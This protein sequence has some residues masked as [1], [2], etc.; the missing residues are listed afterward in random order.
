[1][2]TRQLQEIEH[3]TDNKHSRYQNSGTKEIKKKNTRNPRNKKN[4][5]YPGN[6]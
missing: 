5:R 1:M 3:Y 4:P 6:L 2:R